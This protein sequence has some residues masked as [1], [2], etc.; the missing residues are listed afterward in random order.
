[1]TFLILVDDFAFG[2][3][4]T[5][6]AGQVDTLRRLGHDA[7]VVAL[8]PPGP[9]WREPPF[10]LVHV[11]VRQHMTVP[12]TWAALHLFDEILRG[13]RID[14]VHS[15]APL[16]GIVACLL[17]ARLNAPV[18]HT[19]HGVWHGSVLFDP[20]HEHF[21][22]QHL[23]RRAGRVYC[24]SEEVRDTLAGV[25][26]AARP[27]VK[28]NAVPGWTAARRPPADPGR[29]AFVSRL[30]GTN[31]EAFVRLAEVLDRLPVA[32]LDVIGD[33]PGRAACETAAARCATPV[34]FLGQRDDAAAMMRD[35]AGVAG[36]GGRTAMEAL[37]AH[38]PFLLLH[39]S[40]PIG[41]MTPARLGRTRRRNYTGRGQPAATA[42]DLLAEWAGGTS[43]AAVAAVR[44]A[45]AADHDLDAAWRGVVGDVRSLP[46][47]TPFPG[48]DRRF[49][50]SLRRMPDAVRPMS[51][52]RM[53]AELARADTAD[54]ARA[55]LPSEPD[56]APSVG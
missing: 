1:M 55:G 9:A 23:F 26:P 2:G 8:H 45:M 20:V 7:L 32:A 44:H 14:A 42:D 6:V 21:M 11:P 50:A 17:S 4:E 33:G 48:L 18:L 43:R 46:R 12:E 49:R 19:A 51:D 37:A 40:G 36:Y 54:R 31:A 53:A 22:R 5:H 35:Y 30:G 15:H 39:E 25:F 56:S 16:A 47:A 3:L 38:R 29:W 34:R 28:R 13:Q 24:V 52:A 10:R 41:L 27:V